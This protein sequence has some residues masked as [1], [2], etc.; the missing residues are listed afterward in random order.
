MRARTS[1]EPSCS[2]AQAARACADAQVASAQLPRRFTREQLQ[3]AVRANFDASARRLEDVPEEHRRLAQTALAERGL[4][5]GNFLEWQLALHARSSVCDTT[6]VAS[7]PVESARQVTL[8]YLTQYELKWRVGH[9]PFTGEP[10]C[11]PLRAAIAMLTVG[12]PAL[13]GMRSC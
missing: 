11:A 10:P 7:M 13:V 1:K 4:A 3:R 5:L 2:P 6:F 9:V 8:S 12:L